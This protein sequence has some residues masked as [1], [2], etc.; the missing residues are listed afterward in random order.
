ML[1][2]SDIARL[3]SQACSVTMNQTGVK[4]RYKFEIDSGLNGFQGHV[5]EMQGLDKF[6]TLGLLRLFE[7]YVA[8][9]RISRKHGSTAVA[10]KTTNVMVPYS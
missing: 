8:T 1:P 9:S 10:S 3:L 5:G 7:E 4:R 6:Q 2:R